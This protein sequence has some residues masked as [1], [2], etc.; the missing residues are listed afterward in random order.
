MTGSE[1]IFAVDLGTSGPKV[2]FVRMDGEVVGTRFEPV[3][4]IIASGGGIEQDPKTWW[5]ALGVAS[6][7]LCRSYPELT[8]AVIGVGVT[9]QWSGTVPVGRDGEP[10]HN[11]LIWMDD[12]GAS[13]TEA[14]FGS[15]V[16]IAG[17]KPHLLARWLRLTG[18][19]PAHSGK[20]TLSHLL[21]FERDRPEI[22][23]RTAVY[24]EPKDWL[25]LK[26]TGRAAATHDSA[27]L[28]WLTDNR[29][30]R[31]LR[32]DTSLIERA[33]VER[34]RLPELIA[35]TD[36]VG[37]LTDA[38]AAHLG[39]PK[40]VPVVGGTPDE[41]SAALGSGA[42][43]PGHGHLYVGTSAWITCHVGY[44]KTSVSSGIASLPGPLPD[45]Y[46]VAN[47]QETAGVSLQWLADK[48][49]FHPWPTDGHPRNPDPDDPDL[50]SAPPDGSDLGRADPD[51]FAALDALA[52][53]ASPGSGGVIFTP[54][55]NGER[56]PVDD[57]TIRA[58]WHHI[59]IE[60]D[61]A[62]L[63]RA[64]FE[65]VAYNLRWL[66]ETVQRFV[67]HDFPTLRIIGGGARSDV[68]CQIIADVLECPIERVAQPEG[69]NLR[70]AAMLT[71]LA[72]GRIDRAALPEMTTIDRVFIP[73]VA[74]RSLH[75]DRFQIFR[76][77]YTA[78]R[79]LHRHW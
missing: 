41:Q 71:G 57:H 78:N 5:R 76:S 11:A 4:L 3:D 65:G 36:V 17:Y 32:W 67:G 25:N 38:A 77:I 52:A 19:I 51:R 26:L 1:C 59:S 22:A 47:V 72:L 6:R 54:W 20:D 62:D 37:A 55:L 28:Y 16:G 12:R 75:H 61:V 10:L 63:V 34:H 43:A 30:P 23:H 33:G 58:G 15:R 24:L 18:G 9:A 74:H 7:A 29:D 31:K 35:A 39:L 69:A 42:L 46:F 44:K 50:V 21:W 49:L 48:V 68:W 64:V 66:N 79:R 40:S 2:A 73:T 56:T 8:A 45:T 13:A 60:N 53:Q 27:V 70:G 14:V